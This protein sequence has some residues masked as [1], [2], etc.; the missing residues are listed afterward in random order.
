MKKNKK[1]KKKVQLF[2]VP[3]P[4]K[5][6]INTKNLHRKFLRTYTSVYQF[7]RFTSAQSSS[8]THSKNPCANPLY[9]PHKYTGN[10]EWRPRELSRCANTGH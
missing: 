5:Y 1:F 6:L 9:L 8:Q 10:S 3:D 2:E 7:R 4:S